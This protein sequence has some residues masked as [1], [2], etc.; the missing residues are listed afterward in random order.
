MNNTQVD[1]I[2]RS[3]SAL[4]GHPPSGVER[5]QAHASQ[6]VIARLSNPAGAT[7][8][9]S[10]EPNW[11]EAQA[12]IY[13]SKH[14]RK[15]GL[16]VPEILHI[17]ERQQTVL[18]EDLGNQTL[19]DY[20]T[21]NRI[22][23]TG[24]SVTVEQLYR[25]ALADLAQF[26]YEAGPQ[27]DFTR[28]YP[29]SAFTEEDMRADYRLFVRAVIGVVG[30][31]GNRYRLEEE[32]SDLVTALASKGSTKTFMYRDFQARNIVLRGYSLGYI[33]FQGGRSGHPAYDVA[34]LLYQARAALPPEVR[35]R[36]LSAYCDA[37][38]KYATFEERFFTAEFDSWVLI[39]LLQALGR[40]GE[41]GLE[42]NNPL[43]RSGFP[44]GVLFLRDFLKT[45][46]FLKPK[47]I[48]SEYVDALSE[49][50]KP[51]QLPN[52]QTP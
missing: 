45:A 37:A 42:G 38:R 8:I 34:S 6:R 31:E 47:P 29:S 24:I 10:F 36:L 41:L 16:A 17:D 48:L 13:L 49:H 21:K 25:Q 11:R 43:F 1:A 14:F 51:A 33:D 15:H 44:Q 23:E 26:Q 28:C 9:G 5:V 22:G 35:S 3:Y 18:M 40:A 20:L 7:I 12:F 4:S 27:V 2:I 30:I 32:L 52:R 50:C 39:R 46:N 19:F